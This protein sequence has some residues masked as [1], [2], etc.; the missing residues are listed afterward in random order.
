M[1]LK[2]IVK[3]ICDITRCKYDVYTKEKVDELLS[4]KANVSEIYTKGNFAVINFTNTAK[5]QVS[6]VNY[7]TGFTMDNCVVISVSMN[8]EGFWTTTFMDS[9]AVQD[10]IQPVVLLKENTIWI[11]E[12]Y[13]YFTEKT[14]TYKIVLMK[15]E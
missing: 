14:S 7:P 10:Y 11:T 4:E 12:Q 8:Y 1:A 2:D 13:S 9:V 6:E 5:K 3:G 15:V